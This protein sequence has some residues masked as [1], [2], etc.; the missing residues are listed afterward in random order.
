MLRAREYIRKNADSL[1]HKKL[2]L[3]NAESLREFGEW[4]NKRWR[5]DYPDLYKMRYSTAFARRPVRPL[6]RR[7][8]AAVNDRFVT[9]RSKKR[10]KRMRAR[11]AAGGAKVGE[12]VGYHTGKRTVSIDNDTSASVTPSN[13]LAVTANVLQIEQGDAVDQRQRRIVNLRGIQL[14]STFRFD[15]TLD[16]VNLWDA[17]EPLFLHIALVHPKQ[18]TTVTNSDFLRDYNAGRNVD[19]SAATSLQQ[20]FNPINT[21]AYHVYFHK[22]YKVSKFLDLQASNARGPVFVFQKYV[23]IKRQIRFEETTRGSCID[24]IYYVIWYTGVT[25]SV[26]NTVSFLNHRFR[27]ILHYREPN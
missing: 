1:I 4:Y 10:T 22:H 5:N 16:G 20:T 8:L 25:T 12:P 27:T 24:T 11:M 6:G 7:R 2:A 3:S 18:G 9:R 13:S 26:G 21:D 17:A 23:P 19:F 15:D 14:Q